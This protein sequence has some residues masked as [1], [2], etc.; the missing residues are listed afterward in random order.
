MSRE[1]EKGKSTYFY[2]ESK[3]A[4]LAG[5]GNPLVRQLRRHLCRRRAGRDHP[6]ATERGWCSAGQPNLSLKTRPSRRNEWSGLSATLTKVFRVS[7]SCKGNA[8]VQFQRETARYPN[9]GDSQLNWR[10]QPKR[11]HTVCVQI[12][13][14]QLTNKILSGKLS[15]IS[16][17]PP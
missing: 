8:G 2:F 13:E 3:I 7:L 5:V 12:P 6:R 4:N 9:H 16:S 11:P 15:P 17:N 10:L 14:N 1:G